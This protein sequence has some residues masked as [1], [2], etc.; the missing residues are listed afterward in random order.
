[1]P[2]LFR[3]EM[4]RVSLR[5]RESL[6]LFQVSRF[7]RGSVM[8]RVVTDTSVYFNDLCDNVCCNRIENL[9][10]ELRKYFIVLQNKY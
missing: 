1:M 9:K 6:R 4:L 7:P 10:L 5:E 3:K 2:L 8:D